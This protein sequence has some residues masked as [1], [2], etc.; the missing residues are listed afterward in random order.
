MSDRFFRQNFSC[1]PLPHNPARLTGDYSGLF[2]QNSDPATVA[3]DERQ[4][5]PS[6]FE[7]SPLS[8]SAPS[9][10][11]EVLETSAA[12]CIKSKLSLLVPPVK[13]TQAALKVERVAPNLTV[14]DDQ[15]FLLIHFESGLQIPEP[16]T[17]QECE[18]I[19]N[20][21]QCWHWTV[22]LKSREPAGRAC[23]LNLLEEICDQP[24]IFRG[25]AS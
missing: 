16:F 24:A 22:D 25:V 8:P 12:Q 20:V 7:R 5:P 17:Q 15:R 1:V 13:P 4:S 2:L 23:L 11:Q 6:T 18:I 3:S 10:S 9:K 14:G 19:R 21:F